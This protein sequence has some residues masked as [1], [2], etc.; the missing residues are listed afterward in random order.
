MGT[1]GVGGPGGG[2]PACS[3]SAVFRGGRDH[4]GE[5]WLNHMEERHPQPAL[6]ARYADAACRAI[7]FTTY[8]LLTRVVL[9]HGGMGAT[10]AAP[11]CAGLR[12]PNYPRCR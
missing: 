10:P 11:L 12:L 4:G 9:N 2:L 1:I 5:I 6:M 3:P 8:W 7:R